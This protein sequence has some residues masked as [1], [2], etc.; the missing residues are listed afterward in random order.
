MS[1]EVKGPGRKPGKMNRDDQGRLL[2]ADGT[3]A[4]KPGR[5]KG[6]VT[7]N[8]EVKKPGKRGRPKGTTNKTITTQV[9]MSKELKSA[10]KNFEKASQALVKAL[11]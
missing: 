2:K 6:K 7:K 3:L 4:K 10:I 5:P 1:E 11:S 9:T 8:T